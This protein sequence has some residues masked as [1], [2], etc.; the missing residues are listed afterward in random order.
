MENPEW[1]VDHRSAETGAGIALMYLMYVDESGDPGTSGSK[2]DH[3]ILTGLVIHE[4][5]WRKT[6]DDLVELR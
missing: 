4:L 5:S 1:E 6:L 3:Y 2:T